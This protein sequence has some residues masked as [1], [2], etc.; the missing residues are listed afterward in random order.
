MVRK[1]KKKNFGGFNCNM[2]MDKDNTKDDIKG[3]RHSSV[4]A[5]NANLAADDENNESVDPDAIQEAIQLEDSEGEYSSS[6]QA[7]EEDAL[8]K[9]FGF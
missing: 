6:A 8:L 7:Q 4:K 5:D 3:G 1:E 9:K 2:N